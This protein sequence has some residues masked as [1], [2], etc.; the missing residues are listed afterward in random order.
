MKSNIMQSKQILEIVSI[1][2]SMQENDMDSLDGS[3]VK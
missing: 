3:D 2:S 1:V